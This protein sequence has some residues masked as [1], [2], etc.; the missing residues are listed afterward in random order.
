MPTHPDS[1][2]L[3]PF[4]KG[5]IEAVF[6]ELATGQIGA[7]VAHDQVQDPAFTRVVSRAYLAHLSDQTVRWG[8]Q[9]KW[10]NAIVLHEL[11][12][13]CFKA[14]RDRFPDL[15]PDLAAD[16]LRVL[17][18]AL[19]YQPSVTWYRAALT[20]GTAEFESTPD[21]AHRAELAHLLGILHLDPYVASR[22]DLAD[23]NRWWNSATDPASSA[24]DPERGLPDVLPALA[25]AERWLRLALEDRHG[26]DRLE[27]LKA[28]I[29]CLCAREAFGGKLDL[30]AVRP[31]Y[32]ASLPLRGIAS[33]RTDILAFLEQVGLRL[34]MPATSDPLREALSQNWTA[35]FESLGLG[36]IVWN[37]TPALQ[38]AVNHDPCRGLDLA[39][40]VR[41]LFAQHATEPDRLTFHQLVI[42]L[43]GADPDRALTRKESTESVLARLESGTIVGDSG[44]P[45]FRLALRGVLACIAESR[46]AEAFQWLERLVRAVPYHAETYATEMQLLG[47]QLQVGIAVNALRRTPP[48]FQAATAAYWGASAQFRAIHFHQSALQIMARQVDVVRRL[49]PRGIQALAEL[50]LEAG[51]LGDAELED[52]W[53][54][55]TA[56]VASSAILTLREGAGAN[57]WFAVFRLA[58]G[59]AFAH[60]LTR[61]KPYDWRADPQA[62]RLFTSYQRHEQ[63]AGLEPLPEEGELFEEI[64]AAQRTVLRTSSGKDAREKRDNAAR[65]FDQHVAQKAIHSRS[66][67][68]QCLT[69]DEAC[70]ALPEDAVLLDLYQPRGQIEASP[71]FCLALTREDTRL[72]GVEPIQGIRAIGLEGSTTDI[73]IGPEGYTVAMLRRAITNP[74]DPER[75]T[76][77]AGAPLLR[78]VSR[79]FLGHTFEYLEELKTRGKR[80]LL[81]VPSGPT[82]F[83]PFHLLGVNGVPLA[84]DWMVTYLPSLDLLR[85]PGSSLPVSGSARVFGLGYT[86]PWAGHQ[87]LP[88]LPS[89]CTEASAIAQVLGVNP[90]LNA[91]A[92]RRAVLEGLASAR[93]AHLA[94]H[95]RHNVVAPGLQCLHLTPNDDDDGRLLAADLLS[96]DLSGLALLGLSACETSLGRVDAGDNLRGFPS[97]ALSAGATTVIGTL[98]SADDDAANQFF[99]RF[100]GLLVNGQSRRDAFHQAQTETRQAFPAFVDWGAFYLSGA[101]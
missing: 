32:E 15:G 57:P 17:T 54:E 71:A 81:I 78:E 96:L 20:V 45:D 16:R 10:P 59:L 27:T 24:P 92:T 61:P 28:L 46:E 2:A 58:K 12:W 48:D 5:P 80:H 93:L 25:T 69:L 95:G 8:Y 23:L 39:A 49:D 14:S 84:Q 56:A 9:G 64:L 86:E 31:L 85:R 63:A 30:A 89:A 51:P 36:P 100:Y 75:L 77:P 13:N 35:L 65:A 53:N 37:V 87:G 4:G 72:F 83:L 41:P 52:S 68:A 73:E 19:W 40:Q 90:I 44:F 79:R 26:M 34:G 7:A 101:W 94:C 55:T 43:L 70:A 3:P 21:P 50:M 18:N 91:Q 74:N 11:V 67:D 88:P 38:Y 42:R 98:W 82:H 47:A 66:G 33:H 97:A 1:P 60:S 99:Q 29:Q 76:S 62:V 22:R 6:R